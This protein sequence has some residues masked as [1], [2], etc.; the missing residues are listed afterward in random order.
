MYLEGAVSNSRLV[1]CRYF[2]YAG[3]QSYA[4][5]NSPV[6]GREQIVGPCKQDNGTSGIYNAGTLLTS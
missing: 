1:R 5:S 2:A 4:A 3:S 6:W